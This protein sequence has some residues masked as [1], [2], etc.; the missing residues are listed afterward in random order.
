[1]VHKEQWIVKAT[2][3]TK[4]KGEK[5]EKEKDSGLERSPTPAPAIYSMH[6]PL[7]TSYP[8]GTCFPWLFA[9]THYPFNHSHFRQPSQLNGGPW[10]VSMSSHSLARPGTQQGTINACC[11]IT[12]TGNPD[13]LQKELVGPGGHL[14]Q[15]PSQSWATWRR[16]PLGSKAEVR[17]SQQALRLPPSLAVIPGPST[18]AVSLPTNTGLR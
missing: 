6:S 17:P 16:T 12:V 8:A 15:L 11:W 2:V 3:V 4:Q 14:V 13:R 9:S 7:R 1:M 5:E 10:Y 18:P